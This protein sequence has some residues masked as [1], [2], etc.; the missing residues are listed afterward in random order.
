MG[1][2]TSAVHTEPASLMPTMLAAPARRKN[3]APM[4]PMAGMRRGYEPGAVHHVAEQDGV[5]ARHHAGSEEEGPVVHR[6]QGLGGDHA[7][8]AF[9]AV[10]GRLPEG[11]DG[12][13][14]D[15]AGDDEG[16][17]E[18]AGGH[19]PEG[20]AF[21]LASNDRVQDDRGAD[22]GECG[23][24]FEESA[25]HDARVGASAED[26]VG[27]VQDGGVVDELRWD[28]GDDG[29]E[30]HDAGRHRDAAVGRRSGS[31]RTGRAR[32]GL[33]GAA[34]GVGAHGGAFPDA[35]M[36]LVGRVVSRKGLG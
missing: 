32:R 25:P 27:V 11:D 14:R 1:S 5:D 13:H 22:A 10:R 15:D 19:E 7:A 24:D 17:L 26:V 33:T 35:G 21:V 12:Q 3:G 29:D 34:A 9:G 30:V 20:G 28:G 6:D 23:D 16:R 31:R 18:H 4:R 36:S 2:V 8:D